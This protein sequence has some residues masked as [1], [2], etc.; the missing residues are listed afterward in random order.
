MTSPDHEQH[1]RQG[2][3]GGD[4]HVPYNELE[5]FITLRGTLA[6]LNDYPDCPSRDLA[7]YLLPF[8]WKCVQKEFK[9]NLE[10][11]LACPKCKLAKKKGVH[12]PTEL[13]RQRIENLWKDMERTP[14]DELTLELLERA[15][16]ILEILFHQDAMACSV[17]QTHPSKITPML[18]GGR[19]QSSRFRSFDMGLLLFRRFINS[20]W[21]VL[22]M[23]Q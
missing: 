20:F 22:A 15:C 4:G 13:I 21:L 1:N 18:V 5:I 19:L 3:R 11:N 10:K 23:D 7:L 2:P 16:T 6:S 14:G 9:K 8:E 17:Q 12:D